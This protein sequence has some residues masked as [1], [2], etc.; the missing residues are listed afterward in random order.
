MMTDWAV[1]SVIFSSKYCPNTARQLLPNPPQ[2]GNSKSGRRG[3][4]N[5]QKIRHQPFWL[6]S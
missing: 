6:M 5:I 4:V 1:Q 2:K 3:I